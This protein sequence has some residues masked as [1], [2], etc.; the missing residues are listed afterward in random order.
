[1]KASRIAYEIA[2][3]LFIIGVLVQVFF[4]GMA[5]VAGRWGWD[6]HINLGHFLAVP[7]LAMLVTAYVGK[8]P[9]R[10]KRLTWLLFGVYVLQGDV[11]IFL[12]A[13]AP[14]LSAFHPVMA[15]I[16]FALGL[17]LARQARAIIR[18]DKTA[19]VPQPQPEGI[20]GD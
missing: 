1:M 20:P 9:G 14:V 12:R 15:L 17:T 8:L 6:N 13:S 4:A 2:G 19:A 16:D 11:L 7:L 3:W 10:M 5:V 18:A